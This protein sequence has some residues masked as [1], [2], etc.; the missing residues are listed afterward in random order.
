MDDA[1]RLSQQYNKGLLHS[2]LPV[3]VQKYVANGVQLLDM[4][5]PHA[6]H[7]LEIALGV[8]CLIVY[9]TENQSPTASIV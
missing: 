5:S 3:Q 2:L 4:V 1:C 8:T 9:H 6:V 7:Q